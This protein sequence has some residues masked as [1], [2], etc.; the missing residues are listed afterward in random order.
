MP[1]A[2]IAVSLERD[3][4]TM[5]DEIVSSKLFSNRSQFVASALREKLGRTKKEQLLQACLQLDKMEEE[6]FA[7]EGMGSEMTEWPEY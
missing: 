4:L 3:L 5:I 6:Q 2:K 1:V 7:E